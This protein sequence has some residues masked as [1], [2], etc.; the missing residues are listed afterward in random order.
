[1]GKQAWTATLGA[2]VVGA[3]ALGAVG[4]CAGLSP[5]ERQNLVAATADLAGRA[6]EAAARTAFSKLSEELLGR[7]KKEGLEPE[8]AARLKEAFEKKADEVA[9]KA[10]EIARLEAARIA[11]AKLPAPDPKGGA[12]VWGSILAVGLAVLQGYA[13]KRGG[14]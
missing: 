13:G 3:L 10:S 12:S 4:G 7:L 1:M 2:A 14:A 9:S 5:E 8:A 6:G 11:E